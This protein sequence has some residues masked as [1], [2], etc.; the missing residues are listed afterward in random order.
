MGRPNPR[1]GR[2]TQQERRYM[3][4]LH[5]G[6]GC[7][8][9]GRTD[10]VE[11]AH[12]GQKSMGMKAPLW[13]CLPLHYSLHREEECGRDRFWKQALTG[14]NHLD[15]AVRLYEC[16]EQSDRMGALVLLEDMRDAADR[17]YLASILAVAA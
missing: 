3:A 10:G 2:F 17:Q 12:T 4:F 7:C 15:W 16:F 14:E 1:T 9:S 5:D 6:L 13:T 8:L 11:V